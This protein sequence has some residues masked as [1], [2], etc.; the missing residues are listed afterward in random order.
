MLAHF[1]RICLLL[2]YLSG[3][4]ALVNDVINGLESV[5]VRTLWVCVGVCTSNL[6]AQ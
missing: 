3:I 5:L 1:L 4:F 6:A 2:I